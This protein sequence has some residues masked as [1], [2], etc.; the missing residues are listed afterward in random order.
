MVGAHGVGRAAVGEEVELAFLD[1]VL[2]VA[3]GAVE[4]FVE[5]PPVDGG[6]VQRGD[7]EARVGTTREP[8]G[9]ADDTALA[10]PTVQGA[11]AELGE[12]A[13][14]L[15]ALAPARPGPLQGRVQAGRQA[16]IARQTE[17][18][19]DA[20]VLAPRHQGLAGE[21]RICA[22]HDLHCRPAG[23]DLPDNTRHL[24]QRAGAGVTIRPPQ[25][26]R[27]EMVAAE[28]VERQIAVAIVVTVEE[29]PLLTP[30]Q[31]VVSGVQIKHQ[32]RRRLLMGVEKLIDEQ[33]LNRAGVVADA[34]IAMRALGRVLQTVQRRFAGQRRTV[35]TTPLK[36]A[37]RHT[38]RRI[39]AQL[40]VIQQVLVAQRNGK[41][42]LA[43]Q[44]RNIV[45]NTIR[46]A[47]IRKARRKPVHQTDRPVRR[48]QQQRA[49]VRRQHTTAKISYNLAPFKACK[50]HRSQTTLC[51]HRGTPLHMIKPLSQK[52]FLICRTPMHSTL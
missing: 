33:R 32:T 26:C 7:E 11:I 15:A 24:L 20:I 1:A 37:K 30:V 48:P 18:I 22:Q 25:L 6:R 23:A 35:P 46:S 52:N 38:Q 21:A 16:R 9:F 4:F 27:Q 8:L 14:R 40:V 31:R 3:S 34:A 50:T 13:G 42:A 47:A 12:Q 45:H 19:I 41:H 28:N 5:G 49:G 39:V 29:P 43:H 2:H 51:R 44:G 10:R 17:D 36:P